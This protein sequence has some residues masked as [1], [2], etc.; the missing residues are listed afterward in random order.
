MSFR[1]QRKLGLTTGIDRRNLPFRSFG[2]PYL[3]WICI[4]TFS[5]V[6]FFNGFPSFIGKFQAEDFVASYITLPIIFTAWL[7]YKVIKRS[8]LRPLDQ[9]DFSRGPAQALVNTHYDTHGLLGQV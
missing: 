7:G 8:K 4:A 2:Q 9:I 3:A 6:I 1:A 5:T